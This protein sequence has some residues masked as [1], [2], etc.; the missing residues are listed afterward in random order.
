[1]LL[2]R[3]QDIVVLFDHVR[4]C[5][6]KIVARRLEALVVRIALVE[7]HRQILHD[8]I[9]TTLEIVTY[10]EFCQMARHSDMSVAF[11]FTT[12][13][14]RNT[15]TFLG[16]VHLHIVQRALEQECNKRMPRL[17]IAQFLEFLFPEEL[18][19]RFSSQN[20]F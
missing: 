2:A 17:M 6:L 19:Q 7:F 13:N 4:L 8:G 1:M 15:R 16:A 9:K 10:Q 18:H 14:V 12:S 5:Q 11:K 20:L 3:H